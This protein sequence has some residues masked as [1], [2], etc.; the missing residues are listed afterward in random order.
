MSLTSTAPT[1]V[2]LATTPRRASPVGY[3][4]GGALMAAACVAA[5]LWAVVAFF[6]YANQVNNMQRMTVPG[7][8][9]IHLT[10]SETRV[11]YY[12]GS[13]PAPALGQLGIHVTGPAGNAVTVRS[14][15]WDLR[16]DVPLIKP[17]RAGRAIASFDATNPGDYRISASNPAV[18]GG[19]IALGGD[20]LRDAVPQI[21]GIVAVLLVGAGAG[22]ALIVITA[23]RRNP[24]R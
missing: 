1:P 22:L 7:T 17:T 9:T 18:T 16:Y 5:A 23:V 11:L 19:T 6:G 8:A 20:L 15:P 2:R 24:A 12:E 3:W 14:Y 21:A 10:Q 4:I 13:G